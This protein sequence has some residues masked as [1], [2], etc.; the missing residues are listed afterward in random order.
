M[1]LAAYVPEL[2][3]HVSRELALDG[4]VIL[5]RILASQRIGEVSK[6]ENGTEERK[7]D[8]RAWSWIRIPVERIRGYGPV[9]PEKRGVEE[10]ITDEC[11]ATKRRLGSKRRQHQLLVAVVEH[12]PAHTHTRFART[13][14]ELRWPAARPVGRPSQPDSRGQGLK[15]VIRQTRGDSLVARQYQSERENRC[16]RSR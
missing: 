7:I 16:G 11:A 3:H 9:L 10:D 1:T 12:P 6:Q 2:Q 14:R 5:L 15:V 4:E 13:T 8:R